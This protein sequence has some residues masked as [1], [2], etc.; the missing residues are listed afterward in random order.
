[1]NMNKYCWLWIVMLSLVLRGPMWASVVMGPQFFVKVE[2]LTM[3]METMTRTDGSTYTR[4]VISFKILDFVEGSSTK[5]HVGK[6]YKT[7]AGKKCSSILKP[8][9][10]LIVGGE[11]GSTMGPLG[12]VAF[13]RWSPIK[14]EKG[15]LLLEDFSW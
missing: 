4:N 7:K 9:D 11:V 5:V 2:V 13:M 3:G 10:N 6:V 15:T 1:M 12:P 8:G 14:N